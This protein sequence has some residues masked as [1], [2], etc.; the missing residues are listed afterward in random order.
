MKMIKENLVHIDIDITNK[1]DA[2]EYLASKA[3]DCDL[4][5]DI[6]NFKQKVFEREAE[7]PTSLGL[8]IAI[9]HGKSSGVNE[10][11]FAYLRTQDTFIWDE[12]NGEPVQSIF[13]IGVPENAD[14]KLHLR[15]LSNISRKLMHEEFRDALMHATSA[16]EVFELLKQVENN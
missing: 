5:N 9:P 1:E 7:I 6:H 11:F 16:H 8:G 14:N 2:I 10:A 15:I 13:M 12:R 4:V 3:A